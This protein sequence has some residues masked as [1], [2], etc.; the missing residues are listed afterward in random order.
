MP[1]VNSVLVPTLLVV[2][3]VTVPDVG[4]VKSTLLPAFRVRPASVRFN[5][6]APFCVRR[7]AFAKPGLK[8]TAPN[9]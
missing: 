2:V 6:A 4:S 3:V 7:I 5:A 8:V 1:L 9:V